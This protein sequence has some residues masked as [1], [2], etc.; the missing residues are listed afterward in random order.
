MLLQKGHGRKVPKKGGPSGLRGETVKG[1]NSRPPSIG[2]FGRKRERG[3]IDS[4]CSTEKKR[5]VL[6]GINGSK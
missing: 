4:D 6:A 3:E 5:I 1:R 2:F